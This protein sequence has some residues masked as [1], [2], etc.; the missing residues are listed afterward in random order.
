VRHPVAEPDDA[1]LEE[2]IFALED[3][4]PMSV[5]RSF[6]EAGARRQGRT[7]G[8]PR[9]E[10]GATSTSGLLRILLVFQALS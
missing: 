3:V 2:G 7:A 1:L 6:E 4:S 5:L 9:T 10:Q 8:V